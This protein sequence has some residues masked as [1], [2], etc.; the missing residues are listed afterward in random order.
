MKR[1]IFGF[2]Y[3][4]IEIETAIL[5]EKNQNAAYSISQYKNTKMMGESA[6][7]D[8]ES[9]M[10]SLDEGAAKHINTLNIQERENYSVHM[11]SN[12]D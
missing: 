6:I 8:V 3:Y 4:I 7:F 2:S 1:N 12:N 5:I 9:L 11:P 10:L